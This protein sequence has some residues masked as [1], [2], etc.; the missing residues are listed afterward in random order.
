ML[1]VY[2]IWNIA[3]FDGK[4]VFSFNKPFTDALLM[5]T[6]GRLELNF[7]YKDN[8]IFVVVA[9]RDDTSILCDCVEQFVDSGKKDNAIFKFYEKLSDQLKY[10]SRNNR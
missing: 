7:C 5:I 3:H 6:K 10:I 1:K 2:K 9:D 4:F 8:D